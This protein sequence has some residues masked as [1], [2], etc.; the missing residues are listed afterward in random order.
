METHA[1]LRASLPLLLGLGLFVGCSTA[2]DPLVG[3]AAA[4]LTIG[5]EVTLLPDLPASSPPSQPLSHAAS[6]SIGAAHAVGWKSYSGLTGTV[7]FW[8]TTGGVISIVSLGTDVHAPPLVL[9]DGTVF[10]VAWLINTGIVA[11]RFDT[12]GTRLDAT[13]IAVSGGGV[14]SIGS[15]ALAGVFDG[16]DFALAYPGGT[17]ANPAVLTRVTTAGVVRDRVTVPSLPFPQRI[18]L[19]HSASGYLVATSASYSASFAYQQTTFARFDANLAPLDTAPRT[20]AATPRQR[21]VQDVAT[22]GTNYL[23]L[24]SDEATPPANAPRL[25]AA[26]VTASTGAV[27]TPVDAGPGAN[28]GIDYSNGAW[29]ERVAGGYLIGRYAATGDGGSVLTTRQLRDTGALVEAAPVGRAAGMNLTGLMSRFHDGA[30][31][32]LVW[33]SRAAPGAA[34]VLNTA[35][36]GPDGS[37][38]TP[39]N[40]PLAVP[41]GGADTTECGLAWDGRH[42]IAAWSD[43]AT[44]WEQRLD[45][46]G[47]PVD[48]RA[49]SIPLSFPATLAAIENQHGFLRWVRE[50]PS[51]IMGTYT[52]QRRGGDL[53]VVGTDQVLAAADNP[54][55]GVVGAGGPPGYLFSFS[56]GSLGGPSLNATFVR[57]DGT[58][59]AVELFHLRSDY[60]TH[61]FAASRTRWAVVVFYRTRGALGSPDACNLTIN[62]FTPAGEFATVPLDV[63]VACSPVAAPLSVAS[64]GTN[65]LVTWSSSALFGL[66]VGPDGTALDA[67][68]FVVAAGGAPRSAWDGRAYTVAWS[69]ASQ[70]ISAVRVDAGGRVLDAAPVVL[71]GEGRTAGP[72]SLATDGAG[73]LA[74]GYR[75]ALAGG[76]VRA[77]VRVFTW[78]APSSD[79]GV[80]AGA[81][82]G[83]VVVMPPLDAGAPEAGT[84]DVTVVEGGTDVAV[85]DAPSVDAG[86][87]VD[88]G[89]R[90]TGVATPT[91]APAR[92]AGTTEDVPVAAADAGAPPIDDGGGC[93]V[94]GGAPASRAS[95]VIAALLGI[96]VAARRRRRAERCGARSQGHI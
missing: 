38:V 51:S 40:Q 53:A 93:S 56:Q 76:V 22:D 1:R 48:A 71:G 82:D 24:W 35:T 23:V 66:R 25:L 4:A 85:I 77:Q 80:D 84:A 69:G 6:A 58:H 17:A 89:A 87:V 78:D 55:V 59:T 88:T 61:A 70:A 83:G 91:D 13:P 42:F 5:R 45:R 33:S 29:A 57:S 72:F 62:Q 64:D 49:T 18:R 34:P 43:N 8:S 16:R 50:T 54:V 37:I 7:A 41:G 20:L 92:D 74:L 86:A 26:Q 3:R 27:A 15:D 19:A 14:G 32:G 73:V 11:A 67:A 44:S 39:A 30:N 21:R 94:S 46:A 95:G 28:G 60:P 10:L 63:P 52:L 36:L 68:P 9:T 79:G 2:P 90:D 81:G 47:A 12:T 75:R 96:T 65:F 31:I